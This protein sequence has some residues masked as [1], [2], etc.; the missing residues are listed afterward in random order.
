LENRPS[1]THRHGPRPGPRR[2]SRTAEH[3][4]RPG[5]TI[6]SPAYVGRFEQSTYVGRLRAPPFIFDDQPRA[7]LLE[8]TL[9]CIRR[10][11][12]NTL[13]HHRA[14]SS[15]AKSMF[16]PRGGAP[17]TARARRRMN[18]NYTHTHARRPR[19]ESLHPRRVTNLRESRIVHRKVLFHDNNR[20]L[21]RLSSAPPHPSATNDSTNRPPS[22]SARGR[23][24]RDP[25]ARSDR[26]RLAGANAIPAHENNVRSPRFLL[27]RPRR[28]LQGDQGPSTS[29]DISARAS[30]RASR[31]RR[32]RVVVGRRSRRWGRN[33]DIARSRSRSRRGGRRAFVA[34]V[35]DDTGPTRAWNERAVGW[36][37]RFI[38]RA[39]EG[40]RGRRARAFGAG[41]RRGRAIGEIRARWTLSRGFAIGGADG[42]LCAVGVFLGS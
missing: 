2:V 37:S 17:P 7:Y 32:R 42:R 3:S 40:A 24:R 15:R 16:P 20:G 31:R 8:R 18:T 29:I 19:R 5:S 34:R 38:R 39:R 30:A 36:D 4:T 11:A 14:S 10:S 26:R 6:G 41:V 25:R 21:D 35:G 12:A 1:K 28:R 22:V 23:S 27:R 33:G 13:D 9:G